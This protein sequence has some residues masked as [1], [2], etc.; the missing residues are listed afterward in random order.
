MP[1]CAIYIR[2]SREE[3]DK[4]SH[5]LTVQ[6]E[7]LPAYATA[8]GWTPVIY[9]DGHA[10]AARGKTD[11]LKERGRMERDIRAGKINVILTIELSRLSRD[12]S[13]QDYVAWLHL[14]GQ[15][16]VKLSTMSRMLDPGHNSDWILLLM[17]G[18]FSSIEMRQLKSRMKEGFDQAFRSGKFVQGV[19]PPPYTYDLA[20]RKPVIDPERL[21][22]MQ[23]LWLLTET[24][25]VSA[26]A[27]ELRLPLISVRRAISDD[28][29][30]FYQSLRLDPDTGQEIICDWES[31]MTAEQA[32]RI[33]AAR[34]TRTNV[35][36]PRAAYAGLMSNMRL[37]FCGYCGRTFKTWQNSRLR[38][39]NTRLDYY[40]CQTSCERSRMIAQPI[41]NELVLNNIFNTL[42]DLDALKQAWIDE[43]ARLD[44]SD[45]IQELN[46]EEVK[47]QQRKARLIEAI[48]EGILQ[49]A[50]A[51]PKMAEIDGALSEISTRR[52]TLNRTIEAPPDFESLTLTR[53]EYEQLDTDDQRTF[54]A[55]AIHR[56]DLY[57]NYAIITYPFPR[58]N[59][60]HTSRIHLPPAERGCGPGRKPKTPGSIVP[61]RP[62]K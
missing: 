33:R 25:S 21:T 20:A 8:Q 50:D 54:I 56:V 22:S 62:K 55:A 17:E 12:D 7:Q 18:G 53:E 23:Q 39:D 43:Q 45:D 47:Q 11:D 13:L 30:M 40:G 9:D 26:T 61:I 5:R 29:L 15:N 42:A 34:R 44:P 4:P 3:K 58:G 48:T 14:C 49:L 27:K 32:A 41:I 46:R 28:R 60:I 10:S 19:P 35:S 51:R 37:L 59:G 38:S 31:C 52:T 2:K 1:T 36:G 16:G 6:R 57:H 24:K